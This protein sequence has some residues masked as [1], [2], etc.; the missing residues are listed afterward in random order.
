M[1]QL[2]PFTD[3]YLAVNAY[4]GRFGTVGVRD[5]DGICEAFDG[6]GFDGS[7]RCMSD[8]HYLCAECSQLSPNAERFEQYGW[9]GVLDRLE[10]IADHITKVEHH[11][12]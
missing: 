2:G 7:G 6:R 5:P 12:Y 11:G 8:G 3:L 9:K 1:S 10:L 4:P